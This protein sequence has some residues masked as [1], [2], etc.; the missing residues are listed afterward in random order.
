MNIANSL[1][2]KHSKKN[3][4]A[5]VNTVI[6][7]PKKMEELMECFLSSDIRICQ[8]AAW[9]LGMLGEFAPDL[10][11]PYTAILL[12]IVK[13]PTSTDTVVRNILRTWKEMDFDEEEE[14]EI[15]EISYDLF[16][17]LKKAIAIRVFS[18]YTCTNIAGKYPELADE[19]IPEI[20]LNL[21]HDSPAIRSSSKQCL[22][23]LH[24]LKGN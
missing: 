4:M 13:D 20:E 12:K 1:E 6:A 3:A 23:K 15:F 14:G 10:I 17:N 22:K 19:L 2:Q 21:D 5:I 16:L 18:M 24:K 11:S 7:N 8:R 9:P